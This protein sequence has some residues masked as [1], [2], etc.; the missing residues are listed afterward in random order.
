MTTTVLE[1]TALAT[2]SVTQAYSFAIDPTPEQANL[3]RSHIGGSRFAYNALLGLV[4]A[5]WDE[6]RQRRGA[7]EE[8]AKEE[9]LGTSH[10]RLLGRAP[11]IDRHP[12]DDQWS[13]QR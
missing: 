3:L 6:N 2:Q 11:A 5:N 1:R 8:V 12:D 9:Y 13:R 4:K 7:G 10:W